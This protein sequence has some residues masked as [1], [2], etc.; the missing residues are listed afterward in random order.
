MNILTMMATTW[1]IIP[2]YGTPMKANMFSI[3]PPL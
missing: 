3:A 2:N 1:T